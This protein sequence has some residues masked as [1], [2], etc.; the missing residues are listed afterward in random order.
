MNPAEHRQ[1]NSWFEDPKV[2][3]L[4]DLLSHTAA[5]KSVMDQVMGDIDTALKD[6]NDSVASYDKEYEDYQVA[7]QDHLTNMSQHVLPTL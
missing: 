5:G 2:G 7:F 6:Y 1:P 4:F 3:H